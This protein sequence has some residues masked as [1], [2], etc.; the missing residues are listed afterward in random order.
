MPLTV[1]FAPTADA[2]PDLVVDEGWGAALKGH[3]SDV[4]GDTLTYLWEQVG[5]EPSV[6]LA[7]T[8]LPT[9]TFTAPAV[10]REAELTFRLTVNDGEFSASDEVVV[11]IRDTDSI[12]VSGVTKI[13]GGG[14]PVGT[15]ILLLGMAGLRR[16]RE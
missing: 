13:L 15:L 3:G 1:N 14:L 11:R 8:S 9:A 2:G 16:K 5:G 10:D 12:A 4:N 6:S 7:G